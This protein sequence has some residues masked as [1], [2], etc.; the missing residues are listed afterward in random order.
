MKY[1]ITSFDQGMGIFSMPTSVLG[2]A[3]NVAL[4]GIRKDWA[5]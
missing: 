3:F 5:H 4:S 2:G 1:I